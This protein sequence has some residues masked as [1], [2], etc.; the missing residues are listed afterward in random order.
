[1]NKEIN[2]NEFYN[3]IPEEQESIISVKKANKEV[4]IYSSSK[5]DCKRI[6][7]RIGKPLKVEYTK[8]R[9]SGMYW[10]IP[11]NDKRL[12]YFLS[13]QIFIGKVQ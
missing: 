5:I 6:M 13:R 10:K 2:F 1:M 11:F 8:G 9:I 7:R 3:T 4:D 12:R